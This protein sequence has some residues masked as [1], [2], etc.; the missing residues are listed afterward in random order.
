MTICLFC[1]KDFTRKPH[2]RW[3]TKF[4]SSICRE[5]HWGINH[6]EELKAIRKRS[7]GKHSVKIVAYARAYYLR[8]R[9]KQYLYTKKWREDNRAR[10]VQQVVTRMARVRGAKGS[11][12]FQEWLEVKKKH[13]FCCARCGR[14]E[15]EVKLTRDHIIPIT[16]GGS[17]YISNIQ[18]LCGP[19]NS[20]KSNHL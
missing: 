3:D 2:S 1:N 14:H 4:C 11:Y 10:S 9:H 12:T 16:K 13:D 17:N 15:S 19:C 7:K 6:I 20:R 8:N 18:P 5:R